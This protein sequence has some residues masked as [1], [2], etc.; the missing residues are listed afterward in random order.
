[1]LVATLEGLPR[2][3]TGVE[4]ASAVATVGTNGQPARWGRPGRL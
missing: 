4:A 2:M 1:M 3:I